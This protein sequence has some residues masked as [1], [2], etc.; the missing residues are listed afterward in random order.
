MN[1]KEVM[2]ALKNYGTEQNRKIYKKHGVK[3][4]L[5]GVSFANLSILKKKIKVE[6]ELAQELWTTNN[7]DAR[8]LAIMIAD[9]NRLTS[10]E[11][12]NWIKEVDYHLLADMI[13]GLV[14]KTSFA[15]KIYGK[16]IQSKK[17]YY[18]QAGYTIISYL[19]KDTDS[20]TVSECKSIL[21]S[22]E[23]EIHQSPN[24]AKHSMN[25]TL[26]AIGIYK[27]ELTDIAKKTAEKIG[28]IEVDHGETSCKTPDA[29]QY[30][31]KALKR[32][33]KK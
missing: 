8:T 30:I 33:K 16:W 6:H 25:M 14:S 5:Y 32:T 15:K 26:I 10:K 28:K 7:M 12:D 23:K 11:I 24:R 20:M 4:E 31:E 19:L 2:S 18:K 29:I 1:L 27:T 13:A 22:I 17:E 3:T 21:K 9:P